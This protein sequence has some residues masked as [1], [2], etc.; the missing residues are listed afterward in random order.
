M[1]NLCDRCATDLDLLPMGSWPFC[2][3]NAKDHAPSHYQVH[4]DEID[5]QIRHGLCNADGSPKRYTSKQQLARDAKAHGLLNYV[6]HVGEK[7]SDKSK[8]TQMW[9]SI[10]LPEDERIRQWWEHE[11]RLQAK[12]S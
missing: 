4:G 8:H 10:P 11:A 3:G 1:A 7:G 12:V 2:H 9:T 6:T 5:V